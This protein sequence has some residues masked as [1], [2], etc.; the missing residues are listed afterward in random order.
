LRVSPM[1]Q[2][3]VSVKCGNKST[4]TSMDGVAPTYLVIRNMTVEKGR[5]FNDSEVQQDA[6]VVVIGPKTAEKLFGTQDPLEHCA[7]WRIIAGSERAG[8]Y[9]RQGELRG[10]KPG[11]P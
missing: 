4:N 5:S 11:V 1:F 9:S 2:M 3:G 10:R 6:R 7:G 8:S